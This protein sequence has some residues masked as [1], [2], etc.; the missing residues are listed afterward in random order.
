MRKSD[1]IAIENF[2]FEDFQEKFTIDKLPEM[3]MI[4]ENSPVY[5]QLCLV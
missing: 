4:E 1:K 2:S 5:F 3:Q